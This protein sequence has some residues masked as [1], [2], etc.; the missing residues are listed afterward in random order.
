MRQFFAA[1]AFWF[2]PDSEVNA[3]YLV[4]YFPNEFSPSPHSSGRFSIEGELHQLGK[5]VDIPELNSGT[6]L[7]IPNIQYSQQGHITSGISMWTNDKEGIDSAALAENNQL[8]IY[9]FPDAESVDSDWTLLDNH[10]IRHETNY[11]DRY[12]RLM[13][14]W[15]RAVKNRYLLHFDFHRR[16]FCAKID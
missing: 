2:F 15:V 13:F 8:G 9:I 12:E 16:R 5:Q 7:E 11:F 14:N 3:G 10:I 6:T 1:P 4:T